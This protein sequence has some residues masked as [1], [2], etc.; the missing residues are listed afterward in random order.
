[1]NSQSMMPLVLALALGKKGSKSEGSSTKTKS[2][3]L[4][5]AALVASLPSQGARAVFSIS[6]SDRKYREQEKTQNQ[7]NE[8]VTQ[9]SE[10]SA[11]LDETKNE[12]VQSVAG[13]EAACFVTLQGWRASGGAPAT[14]DDFLQQAEQEYQQ[15]HQLL[16]VISG[17]PTLPSPNLPDTVKEVLRRV[18]SKS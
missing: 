2:R 15:R 13:L 18:Y 17:S 4:M 3:E 10:T 14:E 16:P 8:S 5:K 11:Q 1:M 12:L 9:L 7:L 6:E